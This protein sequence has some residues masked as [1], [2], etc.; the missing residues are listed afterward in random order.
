MSRIQEVAL[1]VA[2]ESAFA[3]FLV[4]YVLVPIVDAG[5][6]AWVYRLVL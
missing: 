2:L 5:P 3:V 4:W 6:P 1:V